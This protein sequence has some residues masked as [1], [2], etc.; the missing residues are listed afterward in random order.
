LGNLFAHL[1]RG[2]VAERV[3]RQAL[4]IDEQ[5]AVEFP[6]VPEYREK[7][8]RTFNNLATLL[9]RLGRQG[10]AEAAYRKALALQE[11][12]AAEFPSVPDYR[13]G[14]ASSHSNLGS[15]LN[16]QGRGG[17]AETAFRQ[18]LP[19]QEKLAAEFR[20]VPKYRQSLALC[21]NNLGLLL[22]AQGKFSEAEAAYRQAMAIQEKLAAQF[23][24]GP[25]HRVDLAGSQVNFGHLHRKNHQ[26]EQALHW[27]GKSIETL[28]GLFRQVKIDATARWFLR[29]AYWGRAEALDDLKRH[30]EA[31]KDWDKAVKLTPPAEQPRFRLIRATSR[32]RAGQVDE[33]LKE[34]EELAK[35]SN[36]LILYNAAC[37]FALAAGRPAEAGAS[38]SRDECGKRA[39]SLLQQAIAQGFKD[40][41]H[42]KKDDDLKAL[43]GRADFQKLLAALEAAAAKKKP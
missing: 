27:Y 23:P 42:M 35:I 7:L 14:L 13:L 30:A 19:I 38:L 37:V 31:A 16:D 25:K 41:G 34:T 5:L 24:Q 10:E 11:K 20:N 18:A 26:P 36:P 22:V 33:A 21:H 4:A 9:P 29:N 6:S 15:L 32:V 2:E 39:V 8:A 28:D 17:E 43:R 12:L 1:G 40:A 3:Y